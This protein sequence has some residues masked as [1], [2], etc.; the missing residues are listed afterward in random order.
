MTLSNCIKA[1]SQQGR[2]LA[3]FRVNC[4]CTTVLTKTVCRKVHKT[5][6]NLKK[7]KGSIH[8]RSDFL[9]NSVSCM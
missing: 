9:L 3:Y 2:L 1:N 5:D 7:L 4:F 6:K 8:Q